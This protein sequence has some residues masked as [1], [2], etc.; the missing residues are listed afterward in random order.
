MISK[1]NRMKYQ[2]VQL[3][4][5]SKI[6]PKSHVL[7]FGIVGLKAIESGVLNSSQIESARQAINR[8]IKR[9]GKIWVTI[10]PNFPITSKPTGTRMGKGKGNVKYFATK[11]ASGRVLFEVCGSNLNMAIA[12]L[13][14]GGTKLPIKTKI[15]S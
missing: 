2:K 1:S 3:G 10:F 9:K 14:I 8:K 12:A 13:K 11:I 5:L 7:K 6:E 4:K 15:F